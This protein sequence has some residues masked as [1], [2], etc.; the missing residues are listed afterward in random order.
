MRQVAFFLPI[1]KFALFLDFWWPDYDMCQYFSEFILFG[2]HEDHW[3]CMS[4][5]LLGEFSAIISL[6]K[7][8]GH[9]P[10]LF[11]WDSHNKYIGP[12]NGIP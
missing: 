4:I 12:C 7:Q 5:L 2:I 8:S 6:G 3:I 10:P 9:P 1:L 11:F